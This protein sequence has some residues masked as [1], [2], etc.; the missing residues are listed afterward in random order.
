MYKL[1]LFSCMVLFSINECCAQDNFAESFIYFPRN[2]HVFIPS[3]SCIGNNIQSDIYYNTYVGKLSIIKTY[4]ADI[5]INVSKKDK[6]NP[7]RYKHVIGLGF[8]N[9][10][11][12]TLFSKIRVISRY[13]I[14]LPI[15][16]DLF[17]SAG[18]AFHL[19]NYTLQGSGSCASGSA[20]DWSGNISAT[21][22]SPSFKIGFSYNDFNNPQMRPIDY[23]FNIPRFVTIYG[24]KIIS[25][26]EHT[27]M[28]GSIK[29]VWKQMYPASY[30]FQLGLIL[31]KIVGV[32][33]FIHINKGWGLALD[34]NS[35]N[36][37][38]N[39]IDF[40]AAYFVPGKNSVINVIQ[41]ELNIRYNL[42]NIK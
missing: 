38:K 5:N 41:Y 8:Y 21:L 34:L 13:S 2:I 4:Y 19:I 24:E 14:H 37:L 3:N 15:R 7:G 23:I 10:R 17:L 12:G 31:S 25:I 20:L 6:A 40:S 9:D 27:K 36:V 22:Y 11:E 39:D 42:K 30:Q 32:N 35:I 28:M 33:S 26:N 18:A 1:L 29:T 16:T